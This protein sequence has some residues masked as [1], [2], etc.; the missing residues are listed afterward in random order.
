MS[1]NGYGEM[2]REIEK[3]REGVGEDE[4]ED[5]DVDEAQ[6]R[7]GIWPLRERWCHCVLATLSLVEKIES[8]RAKN[9]TCDLH[10]VLWFRILWPIGPN[11]WVP[12]FSR[13]VLENITE[14]VK[15]V[16]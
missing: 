1:Q 7:R 9:V 14:K 16:T 8:L 6:I 13:I 3:K 12:L 4:D 10:T 11:M 5:D 15:Y 2:E